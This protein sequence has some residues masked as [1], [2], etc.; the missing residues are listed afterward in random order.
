MK[1]HHA[2]HEWRKS[3]YSGSGG[4][5]CLEWRCPGDGWVA[6]RDSTQPEDAVLHFTPAAWRAFV[7]AVKAGE[8]AWDTV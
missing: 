1:P 2:P 7:D 5:N 8:F 3:S 4:S 6:V